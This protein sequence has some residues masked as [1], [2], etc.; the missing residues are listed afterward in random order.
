MPRTLTF[1]LAIMVL[2]IA[3][4]AV[5][6]VVDLVGF[7]T[8]RLTRGRLVGVVVIVTAALVAVG[9]LMRPRPPVQ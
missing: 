2:A 9:A 8:A 4:L 1:G 3:I 7:D 5:L 6:S